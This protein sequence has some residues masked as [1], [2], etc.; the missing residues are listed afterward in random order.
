MKETFTMCK[1][2]SVKLSHEVDVRHGILQAALDN[3]GIHFGEVEPH[4]EHA[5]VRAGRRPDNP[6]GFLLDEES[7][8]PIAV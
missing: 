1:L 7:P 8:G 4:A 6:I 3:I 2:M 5:E